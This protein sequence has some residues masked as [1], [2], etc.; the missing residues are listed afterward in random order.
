MIQDSFIESHISRNNGYKATLF[1]AF[2]IVAAIILIAA[3]NI[4]PVLLGMNIIFVTGMLSAAIVWGI[5][6][7]IRRLDIEYEIEISNDLFNVARILAKSKR[8]ELAEFSIRD[9]EHIGPVTG[10]RYSSDLSDSEFTLKITKDN[11]YPLTED[12]WYAFVNTEGI[13]FMVVF[14]FKPEMYPV[15]RRYNPRNTAVYNLKEA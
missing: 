7:L 4:V 10:D 12:Y 11:N 15:F 14:E 1:K 9:C 3:L 13:R 5:V 6:V 8:E 2:I